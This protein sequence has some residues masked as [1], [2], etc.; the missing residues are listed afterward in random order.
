MIKIIP[1]LERE[2]NGGVQKIYKFD[3]GYGAS[4][5]QHDFSYGRNSDQWELAVIKFKEDDDWV[6]DYDT[7][8][9]D[10][11]IGYLEK[12]EVEE[13]LERIRDLE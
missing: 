5:V 6:L 1:H 4:V 9:T 2:L 3:N 13:L 11:V 10:D 12:E 7:P 8:I